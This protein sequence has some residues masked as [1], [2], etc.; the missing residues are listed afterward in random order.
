LV[1]E[2]GEPRYIGEDIG[3]AIALY[4]DLGKSTSAHP[5]F[6]TGEASLTAIDTEVNGVK[7]P[8]SIDYL[9]R[10]LLH[11]YPAVSKQI[12]KFNISIVVVAEDMT[13]IASCASYYDDSCIDNGPDPIKVTVDMGV[14]NLNSGIYSLRVVIQT[15]EMD[16]ILFKRENA[17]T[18]KINGP[19]KRW[20]PIVIKGNWDSEEASG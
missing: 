17:A 7:N 6:E 3:R 16:R 12:K 5:D 15:E 19:H 18:L 2:H 1:L 11:I 10:L 20:T 9:D 4:Y 8:D 13:P 14:L